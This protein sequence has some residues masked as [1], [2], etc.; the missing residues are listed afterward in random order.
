MLEV[1]RIFNMVVTNLKLNEVAPAVVT[2]MDTE[3]THVGYGSGTAGPNPSDTTL[4]TETFRNAKFS[5]IINVGEIRVIGRL[6]TSE[7]NNSNAEIGTFD[8][9]SS[10]N[11]SMHNALNIFTKTSSMTVN[12]FVIGQISVRQI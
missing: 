2:D 4:Q 5:S 9:A 10:G 12:Y 1:G 3:I 6:S 11:M 8:A 7:N